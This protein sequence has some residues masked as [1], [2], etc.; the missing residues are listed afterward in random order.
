MMDVLFSDAVIES[1]ALWQQ[2][3]LEYLVAGGTRKLLIGG[4]G[5]AQTSDSPVDFPKKLTPG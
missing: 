2:I 3:N 1:R 5:Q 4:R